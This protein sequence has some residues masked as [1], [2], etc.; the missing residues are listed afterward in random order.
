MAK[1]AFYEQEIDS[2]G[3]TNLAPVGNNYVE[4]D[5]D[6]D[7]NNLYIKDG[8]IK[9]RSACPNEYYSFDTDSETWVDNRTQ[10]DLDAYLITSRKNAYDS[11][12]RYRGEVRSRYI[13]ICPGQEMVYLEKERQA[14]EWLNTTNGDIQD[15]PAIAAEIG[16]GLTGNTATEVAQTYVAMADQFRILSAIIEAKSIRY[17]NMV[18]VETNT[19]ILATLP[20]SFKTELDGALP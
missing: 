16:P 17:L 18:G 9:I 10:A 12:N 8:V 5:E 6:I 19:E 4:I 2:I 15:F 11:I 3:V 20:V 13:T 7:P 14:R 1:Y